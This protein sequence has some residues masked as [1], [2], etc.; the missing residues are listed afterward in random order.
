MRFTDAVT[1]PADAPSDPPVG[2]PAAPPTYPLADPPA[3]SPTGTALAPVRRRYAEWLAL[4]V[5]EVLARRDDEHSEVRA[6]QLILRLERTAT[7]SWHRAL[8][9]AATACAAVCLDPRSEP[10]GEWFE[11]V[12][13]YCAGQIRKV[14]RRARGAHWAATAAIPGLTLVAGATELRAILP[15]PVTELDPRV[16]RLQVGGT[17]LPIDEPLPASDDPVLE[18]F[19]PTEP[20]MTA[21]KLMAQTGHAGMIAAALLVGDDLSALRRWAAAGCPTRVRRSRP[22]QFGQLLAALADPESAWQDE[23][24]LAVRDAG[25]TEIAPGTVTVIARAPRN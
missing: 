24:L 2:P 9:L 6:L 7:P 11:P 21:G 19:L 23:R 25:F 18:L 8:E 12:V 20:A 5:T 22:V 13:A 15:G 16:G 1:P 3:D 10:G 17:E 14:T 4:D